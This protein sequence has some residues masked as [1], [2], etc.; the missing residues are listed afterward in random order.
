MIKSSYHPSSSSLHSSFLPFPFL[1][2][3]LLEQ[4][5]DPLHDCKL[6]EEFHFA[7]MRRNFC[8]LNRTK[9]TKSRDGGRHSSID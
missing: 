3:L 5:V 2:L 8:Y 1:A 7:D 9:K 6:V 4:L